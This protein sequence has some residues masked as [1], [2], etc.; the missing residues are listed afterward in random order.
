MGFEPPL[1]SV[2]AASTDARPASS[3]PAAERV[4]VTKL[5]PDDLQRFVHQSNAAAPWRR[6]FVLSALGTNGSA[7]AGRARAGSQDSS[8][9]PGERKLSWKI[10]GARTGGS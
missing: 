5:Q 6:R 9:G 2:P 8:D 1:S 7:S 10:A 4:C 3:S